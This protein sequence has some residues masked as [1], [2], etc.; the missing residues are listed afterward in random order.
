MALHEAEA[1]V[2]GIVTTIVKT[3]ITRLAA[4]LFPADD[5][6]QRLR[7]DVERALRAERPA[8]LAWN[9]EPL[10]L[11]FTR[12]EFCDRAAGCPGVR[13][14]DGRTLEITGA[15]FEEVFRGFLACVRLSE[16]EE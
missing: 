8:P 12:V 9:G 16:L 15:S 14:L 10:R 13:R 1:L 4:G 3:G 2:P 11:T 6:R 7:A 5:V